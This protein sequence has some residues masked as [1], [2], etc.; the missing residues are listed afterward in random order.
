MADPKHPD[1]EGMLSW[2]GRPFDPS[3]FDFVTVNLDLQ[4]IKL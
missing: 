3:R 4:D 2:Y 1:H